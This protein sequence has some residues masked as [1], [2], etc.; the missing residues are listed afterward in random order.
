VRA[1]QA[2]RLPHLKPPAPGGARGVLAMDAAT[3][4]SL[5]I[6]R[7]RDSDGPTLMQAVDRT[8]TAGGARLL[9]AR[10]A[11]P[12]TDAAAIAARQDDWVW[13]AAAP[14]RAPIRAALKRAPDLARALARLALGRLSPRD[15]GAVRDGLQA[16]ALAA[17]A[18]EGALPAGLAAL[19]DDLR[20]DVALLAELTRALVDSPPLRE[21]D[22]PSV[23][24]DYD[25]E[26]DAQR[27]LRDDSR[28]VIAGLQADY[29]Q[30]FGAASL[31][32]R[33]HAQLGYVIEAKGAA[34]RA[35]AAHK[36]LTLC[37]TMVDGG[38]W[39]T[40]EL[41]ELD[42][43]INAAAEG[44]AARERLVL[45]HLSA[46]VVRAKDAISAAA[47]ALAA[48][49]VAQS[50]ASLAE[51]TGWCRPTV[52]DD[53]A[54]AVVALRHPVVEQALRAARGPDFVANDAQL[55]PGQRF[56]LLTGPNMAGKSTF[57]RQNALAVVLAQAGLPVPAA[58]ARIGIADR[59]FSRVGAADELARGRST[60]MVEMTEMASIL[61]QAGPRSFVIVDE[62][63]R[64][65][66][67]WD[68]LA[69]AWAVTE[70]LHD[71]IRCR[72]IFA[73]HFHE[74]ARLADRLPNLRP[75]TMR[76]RE[77][78]GDVVFLHEVAEGAGGRS[79]GV[80]VARLAGVP[81]P[82]VA[83]AQRVLTTLERHEDV[84]ALP[85]FSAASAPPDRLREALDALDPDALSP[86]AALDALVRLK[87][88]AAGG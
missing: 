61:R 13:L 83:R 28:Q 6:L 21:G 74:L 76:V 16:A 60:F 33:H 37:Q 85:L 44:A 88:L 45:A 40:A 11:A 54:F 24:P 27:R 7:A 26:L 59:L 41:A 86:R 57:L 67:T 78:K 51:G 10:L 52:T 18:L 77:W 66:A 82:V 29:A 81:A 1:T 70:A 36:D 14:A 23:A 58:S 17:A 31:R 55:G 53:A 72:T 62:I 79:Y 5:E 43:R 2:G 4:A 12:L 32:I 20:V 22:G 8:L 65:T 75:H 19:T 47:D 25:G 48:L 68:G 35:L 15:L 56:M 80:Q 71:Q 64:G 30:R 46:L 39:S 50:A 34:A 3:R 9:A 49:D 73:T 38:R 42:A 87:A 84:G 63:G 69:I